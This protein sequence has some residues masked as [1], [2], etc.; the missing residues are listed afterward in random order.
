[1]R[2]GV[3]ESYSILHT[4]NITHATIITRG[5]KFVAVVF[6][7]NKRIDVITRVYRDG[8]AP[9]KIICSTSSSTITTFSCGFRS[10][11]ST[12]VTTTTTAED[13]IHLLSCT[14]AIAKFEL[15]KI[16]DERRRRIVTAA[17]WEN[18][19]RRHDA[20]VAPNSTARSN[21]RE[22]SAA[23]LELPRRLALQLPAARQR[24]KVR[25]APIG[26]VIVPQRKRL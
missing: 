5:R 23:L 26:I 24:K 20:N 10:T 19:N 16:N 22:P 6:K 18:N 11:T 14:A 21:R 3:N 25:Q 2:R 1:M 7:I 17:L 12:E 4:L 9:P 8:R 15:P 13:T